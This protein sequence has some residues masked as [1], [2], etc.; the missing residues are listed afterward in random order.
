MTGRFS[1]SPTLDGNDGT[2][3][4]GVFSFSISGVSTLLLFAGASFAK[5]A[6]VRRLSTIEQMNQATKR[7]YVTE[8]L[9]T[10]G[11]VVNHNKLEEVVRQLRGRATVESDGIFDVKCDP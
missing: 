10:S 7:V 9:F 2:A 4:S 5:R 11:A 3:G 6:D 8:F 1:S